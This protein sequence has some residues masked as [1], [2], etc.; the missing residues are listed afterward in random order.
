[1]DAEEVIIEGSINDSADVAK[2]IG[3]CLKLDEK[4][5]GLDQQ[6]A[7]AIAFYDREREKVLKNR[8][9]LVGQI[10][11][12]LT[13][14]GHNS[15]STHSGSI[16]K[17]TRRVPVWPNDEEVVSWATRLGNPLLLRT[18]VTPVKAEITKLLKAGE[19]P[20]PGYREEQRV[21][22][23]VRSRD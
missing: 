12:W 23:S 19:E 13:M 11:G 22:L 18:T 21:S 20:P 6:K 17:T 7:E 10:D 14:G 1:M 15:L 16:V 5:A 3:V 9:Y 4:V 2:Y 8:E